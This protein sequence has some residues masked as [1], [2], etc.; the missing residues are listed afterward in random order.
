[1]L[2]TNAEMDSV[3]EAILKF[4]RDEAVSASL[5]PAEPTALLRSI[6]DDS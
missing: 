4:A 5:R 1:M 2:S 3:I 6:I